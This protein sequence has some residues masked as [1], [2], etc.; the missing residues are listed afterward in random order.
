MKTQIFALISQA[1]QLG[2]PLK[3]AASAEEYAIQ[4][5]WGLAFDLVVTQLYEHEIPVTAEIIQAIFQIGKSMGVPEEEYAFVA[6]L[7]RI[8]A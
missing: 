7:P 8:E 4:R 1:K 2:L 3:D 5:E 6:A